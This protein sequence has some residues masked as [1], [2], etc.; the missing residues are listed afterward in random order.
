MQAIQLLQIDHLELS[1]ALGRRHRRRPQEDRCRYRQA[2]GRK[3]SRNDEHP[4][5]VQGRR[6]KRALPRATGLGGMPAARKYARA[7]GSGGSWSEIATSAARFFWPLSFVPPAAGMHSRSQQ[8]S[9]CGRNSVVP[10]REEGAKRS[11]YPEQ[12]VQRHRLS[13]GPL[14]VSSSGH[15]GFHA[16]RQFVERFLT[17]DNRPHDT[18]RSP[19]RLSD[20]SCSFNHMVNFQ[21]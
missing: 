5:S 3:I 9:V 2:H 17:R 15:K 8:L 21:I 6:E 1:G 16:R 13:S 14:G 11:R 18:I 20:T 10:D 4:S 7:G 12:P 19:C